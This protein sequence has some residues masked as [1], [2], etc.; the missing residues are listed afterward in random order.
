MKEKKS[1]GFTLIELLVVIAIIGILAVVILA[2]LGTA[3]KAAA[4]AKRAETTRNVMTAV[5]TWM[6]ANNTT[7]P[8]SMATLISDGY[9]TVDPTTQNPQYVVSYTVTGNSYCVLSTQYDAKTNTWF[10]AKDGVAN[11]TTTAA[12]Q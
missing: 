9:L 3:R 10:Y 8:P 4:D 12:C 6:S 2:A 7:T 11:T 5:E 1:R